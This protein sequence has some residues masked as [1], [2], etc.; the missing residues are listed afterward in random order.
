MAITGECFCGSIKYQIDGKL[1]DARSC[2]CSRCRKVFS[3]QASAYALVESS[4]FT[5][6]QGRELLTSFSS[7]PEYGFQFCSLC[8]STLCG[9]YQGLPHGVT[10]GCLNGDPEVDIDYHLYVGSKAQ[11]EILPHGIKAF[12]EGPNDAEI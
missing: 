1:K 11:W 12:N 6:L 4:E 3:G 10:L 8:G 5:W 7:S 2:H 9:T